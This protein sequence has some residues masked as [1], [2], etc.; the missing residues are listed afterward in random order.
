[1]V[2]INRISGL[3][4]AQIDVVPSPSRLAERIRGYLAR[5]PE[6]SPDEFLLDAV[7]REIDLLESP[8]AS[9]S[10]SRLT[11]EDIRLHVWLSERI[12]ALH[13]ERHGL[14]SRIRRLF[15]GNR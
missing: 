9:A 2:A 7:H 4:L 12:T 3:S 14:W 15:F 5:H 8:R 1:M 10:A 13:R 6:V 11:E